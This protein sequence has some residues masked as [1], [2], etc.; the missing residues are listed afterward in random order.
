MRNWETRFPSTLNDAGFDGAPAEALSLACSRASCFQ[1]L[2]DL[3]LGIA[4]RP[5]RSCLASSNPSCSSA[6]R[7]CAISNCCSQAGFKHA[8]NIV[9]GM[10]GDA[11]A[12]SDSVAQA[13]PL[14]DGW[15][16]SDCPWTKKLTPDRMVLP[17]P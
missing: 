7:A 3:G 16:N 8:Y 10:E 12:D 9:D 5:I 6:A 11:N 4:S 17:K 14:K 15:K 2:L 13:P 1:L